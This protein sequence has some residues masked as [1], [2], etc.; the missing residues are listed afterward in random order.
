M[1]MFAVLVHSIQVSVIVFSFFSVC[2]FIEI[3]NTENPPLKISPQEGMEYA[4]IFVLY[5]RSYINMT[6]DYV[7]DL[8]ELA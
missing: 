1:S 6:I 8:S 7:I 2:N 3:W 4:S 5:T